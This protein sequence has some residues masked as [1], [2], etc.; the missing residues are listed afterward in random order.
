MDVNAITT[1]ISTV[2]FPIFCCVA[3]FW[4]LDK[5][6][7]A[8][9]EESAKFAEV[10]ERNTLALQELSMKLGGESDV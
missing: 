9:K 2:G 6:R 1:I 5:E 7:Q 3:M 10:V 4:Y 8:H